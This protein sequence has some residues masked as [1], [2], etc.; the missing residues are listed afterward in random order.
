MWGVMCDGVWTCRRMGVKRIRRALLPNGT[1]VTHGT[2]VTD[3]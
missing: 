1:Y 2:N 3:P